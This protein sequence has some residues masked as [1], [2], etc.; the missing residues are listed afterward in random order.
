MV[1]APF[2]LQRHQN[3]TAS[4]FTGNGTVNVGYIERNRHGG[5]PGDAGTGTLQVGRG[6]VDVDYK[7]RYYRINIGNGGNG[8]VTISNGGTLSVP[9]SGAVTLGVG[10][11][12]ANGVTYANLQILNGGT[13]S[14][15][16]NTTIGYYRYTA[17]TVTVDGSHSVWNDT[18]STLFV[19]SSATNSTFSGSGTLNITNGA[20]VNATSATTYVGATAPG[21]EVNGLGTLNF[22]SSNGGTLNTGM[23]WLPPGSVVGERDDQRHRA[24]S[25]LQHHGQLAGGCTGE[26][27]SNHPQSRQHA[28]RALPRLQHRRQLLVEHF[29][30]ADTHHW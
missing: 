12:S 13:F 27:R 20:T 24:G 10:S 5:D 18:G 8:T 1:P 23:I 6:L 9:N 29:Q 15:S 30:R 4:G 2:D 22:G 21:G 14:N 16:G 3:S 11:N 19:G 25:Q 17:G 7:Q 26:H 28:Q